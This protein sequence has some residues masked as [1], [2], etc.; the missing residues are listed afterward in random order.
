MVP[1]W[2]M[3]GESALACEARALMQT[4]ARA[5]WARERCA[6]VGGTAAESAPARFGVVRHARASLSAT[7]GPGVQTGA[8][9]GVADGSAKL[10]TA[11]FGAMFSL[12]ARFS[13]GVPV[14]GVCRPAGRDQLST[15]TSRGASGERPSAIASGN[16]LDG[17]APRARSAV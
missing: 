2:F 14:R 3:G 16:G 1:S 9:A 11:E 17:S 4:A 7:E 12:C 15:F 13:F 6:G 10:R 8:N 5:S